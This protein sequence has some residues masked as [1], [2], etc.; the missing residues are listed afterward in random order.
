[1]G[2]KSILRDSELGM[3][4]VVVR[5]AALS[6]SETNDLLRFQ[7]QSS[8]RIKSQREKIQWVKMPEVRGESADGFN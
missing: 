8:G 6:I 4:E 7:A 1:M 2:K 5:W 3:A